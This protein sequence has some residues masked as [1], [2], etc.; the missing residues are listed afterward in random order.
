MKFLVVLGFVCLACVSAEISSRIVDGT[1]ITN[2]DHAFVTRIVSVEVAGTPSGDLG[3]MASG[4]A[5]TCNRVLTVAQ[6]IVGYEITNKKILNS[7]KK[8]IFFTI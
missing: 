8:N 3:Y 2:Q 1:V 7:I 5:I 4:V 6:A